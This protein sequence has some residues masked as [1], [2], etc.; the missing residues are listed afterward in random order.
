LG[1]INAVANGCEQVVCYETTIYVP[2]EYAVWNQAEL[3]NPDDDC[4][5]F[6]EGVYDERQPA[7]V[8]KEELI[9]AIRQMIVVRDETNTTRANETEFSRQSLITAV[10]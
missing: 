10:N 7:W 8:S 1:F 6:V 2:S 9:T 5:E 4:Y 3:P